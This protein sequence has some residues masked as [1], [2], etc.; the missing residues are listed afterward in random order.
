MPIFEYLISTRLYGLGTI[1][2]GLSAICAL[3]KKL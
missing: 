3:E 1:D 2:K